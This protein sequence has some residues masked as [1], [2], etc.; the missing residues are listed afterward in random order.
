MDGLHL[1]SAHCRSPSRR[2]RSQTWTKVTDT[3]LSIKMYTSFFFS[4]EKWENQETNPGPIGQWGTTLS[5]SQPVVPFLKTYIVIFLDDILLIEI[6]VGFIKLGTGK[7]KRFLSYPDSTIFLQNTWRSKGVSFMF[8]RVEV[9]CMTHCNHCSS[10]PNSRTCYVSL[11]LGWCYLNW[12][13]NWLMMNIH[14]IYYMFIVNKVNW[15][16]HILRKNCPLHDAIEGQLA[17]VKGVGRR[18]R[19]LL[20]DL[21]NTRYWQLMEEAEDRKR[22]K[23]QFIIR[24]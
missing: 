2:Q 12:A 6:P 9:M 15:I 5:S 16:E 19:Q 14:F 18:R 17:E 23:R 10:L 24:T 1:W 8:A 20:G 11:H 22:K 7:S 4:R 13:R 21:K 3:S